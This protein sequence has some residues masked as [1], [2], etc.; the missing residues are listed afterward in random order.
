MPAPAELINLPHAL[1]EIVVR[2]RAEYERIVRAIRWGELPVW[3]A[4]SAESLPA[5]EMLGAAFQDLLAWPLMVR[6]ASAFAEHAASMLRPGSVVVLFTDGTRPTH[7]L[8]RAARKRG[9]QVLMVTGGP[10]PAPAADDVAAQ[11]VPGSDLALALP[12]SGAAAES[13]LGIACLQQAAATQLALICA[14]RLTRPEGRLDRLEHDWRD[15]P[16]H[17]DRMVGQLADGVAALARELAPHR[18]ILLAGHGHYGPAARR[19]SALARRRSRRFVV[20][21][22]GPAL[23]S[24]W[25]QTLGEESAVLM[26]SPS[27]G[28]PARTAVDLAPLIKERGSRLFVI[29]G[30]NHY[31]LIRQARLSLTLPELSDLAGSLLVLAAAGWLGTELVPLKGAR[32][33]SNRDNIQQ[34]GSPD[35]DNRLQAKS[36]DPNDPSKNN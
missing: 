36:N 13:E 4:A 17:L 5:A 32:R 29:T 18:P 27:G 22:D 31:D 26:I 9:A 3:A 14:R 19:A 2:Q 23:E 10:G 11:T 34:G 1:A 20:G 15:L 12:S 6:E 33:S 8:A 30:S 24:G 7:D 35:Q 16:S 28:R 21:V 25:L